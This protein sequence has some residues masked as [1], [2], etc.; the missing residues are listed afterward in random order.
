MGSG[1]GNLPHTVIIHAMKNTGGNK[2][3]VSQF[4]NKFFLVS[5]KLIRPHYQCILVLYCID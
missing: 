4:M 2:N 5:S 3:I 1:L